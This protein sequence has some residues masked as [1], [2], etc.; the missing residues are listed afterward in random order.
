MNMYDQYI[1]KEEIQSI[2]REIQTNQSESF[3]VQVCTTK[4]VQDSG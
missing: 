4:G 1:K 3:H 2:S